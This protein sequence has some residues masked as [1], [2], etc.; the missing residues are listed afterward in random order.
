MAKKGLARP[1]NVAIVW[2]KSS[3]T[4]VW[5]LQVGWK[6]FNTSEVFMSKRSE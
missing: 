3:S 6:D 4:T 1:G 2:E 5:D